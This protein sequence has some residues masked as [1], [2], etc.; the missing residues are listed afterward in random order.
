MEPISIIEVAKGAIW[1]YLKISMPL[2][3]IALIVGLLVSFFQALTQ[4]Q[5]ATLSFIP[6]VILIFLSLLILFPF[7]GHSLGDFTN[8]LFSMIAGLG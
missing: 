8:D 2:L 4:I 7:I 5:E 6:K 3:L 1:V